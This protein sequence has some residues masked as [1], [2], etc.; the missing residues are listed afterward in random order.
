MFHFTLKPDSSHQSKLPLTYGCEVWG[1]YNLNAVELLYR[2]HLKRILQVSKYTSNSIV[3]GEL[4]SCNVDTLISKRM[5]NFWNSLNLG[6]QNKISA[7]L[8]KLTTKLYNTDII[9]TKWLLKIRETLIRA[10]IPYLWDTEGISTK[11]LKKILH[12][13]L[14]DSFIQEWARDIDENLLCIN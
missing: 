1:H 6:N 10:G 11:S 9:K 4:G 2:G 7:I 5:V 3:Y 8:L 13:N 14:K 12:N